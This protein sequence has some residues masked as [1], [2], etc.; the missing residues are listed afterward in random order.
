MCVRKIIYYDIYYDNMCVPVFVCLFWVRSGLFKQR[1]TQTKQYG[2]GLAYFG[3]TH[4]MADSSA[5]SPWTQP[6]RL[7]KRSAARAEPFLLL[8]L[9]PPPPAPIIEASGGAEGGVDDDDDGRGGEGACCCVCVCGCCVV[10]A[11]IRACV[12]FL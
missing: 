3:S 7:T 9:L 1:Q 2:Q 8:L 12:L 10:R 11:A 5:V 4:L 6:T